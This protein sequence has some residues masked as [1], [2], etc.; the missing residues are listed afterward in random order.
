[1]KQSCSLLPINKA[2]GK[3]DRRFISEAD[4]KNFCIEQMRLRKYKAACSA[5]KKGKQRAHNPPDQYESE[6][7]SGLAPSPLAAPFAALGKLALDSGGSSANTPADSPTTLPQP[8]LPQGLTAAP[9]TEPIQPQAFI[10]ISEPSARTSTSRVYAS[11]LSQ[12]LAGITREVPGTSQLLNPGISDASSGGK[13]SKADRITA[14]EKRL[15]EVESKVCEFDLR[16][17]NLGV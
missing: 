16:L 9:S 17:K 13:G 12:Y 2:T 1:M 8:S 5:V 15:S 14:L 10:D 11:T 6:E 7:G 4:L 3:A